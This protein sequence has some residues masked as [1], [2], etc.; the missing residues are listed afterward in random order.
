MFCELENWIMHKP[1]IG[2]PSNKVMS[3]LP[4][5]RERRKEQQGYEEV[6]LFLFNLK[7]N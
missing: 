3:C 7:K 6:Y 2:K 1:L 4:S 5:K